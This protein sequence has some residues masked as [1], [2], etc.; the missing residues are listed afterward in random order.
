MDLVVYPGALKAFLTWPKFSLA[1]YIINSRLKKSNVEPKTII[2]VGANI[3]QFSVAALKLFKQAKIISIEPDPE[4][5]IKLKNNIRENSNTEVI[6]CAAGDKTGEVKFF[7]NKDSQVSSIMEIGVI[8]KNLFP[9]SKVKAEVNVPM[10]TLDS[11]FENRELQ[12]PILLKLDVQ[13]AELKVLNGSKNLL[14]NVKWIV[15]E[16]AFVNLYKGEPSFNELCKILKQYNFNFKKPLNYHI[17]PNR[18]EIIEM[19]ALFE[20]AEN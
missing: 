19:D 1:S 11:L 12:K 17:S 2:D 4:V 6:V 16:V 14:K 10:N 3:G 8:R 5:A 7:R 9:N 20:K 13:G 15:I 18:L